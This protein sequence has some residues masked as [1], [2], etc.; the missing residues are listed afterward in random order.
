VISFVFYACAHR[1]DNL[2]QTLRLLNV[3]EPNL[4]DKEIIVVFQDEG[5]ELEGVKTV[6][7]GLSSYQKPV[8]CN[9]GVKLA[10]YPVVALLDSDRILPKDYFASLITGLGKKQFVTVTELRNCTKPET[11][12]AIL[13]GQYEFWLEKRSQKNEFRIKNLF[14]GNTVFF[15]DD[16]LALG[17][18][19]ERYVGYGYADNDMSQTVLSGGMKAVYKN[20]YEIHLYH[21]RGVKYQGELLE[22]IQIQSA[23]NVLKYCRKWRYFDDK[24][25]FI[26]D[27]VFSKI[28]KYPQDLRERFLSMYR[29]TFQP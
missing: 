19:D 16:Y 5:P 26:C 20:D 28:H 4:P 25:I 27:S 1:L 29:R 12:D 21:P 23:I 11:D 18:M 15:K 13:S 10:F 14:S 3:L 9:V 2:T 24:V 8:Q 22:D 17:G 7:L 6:N